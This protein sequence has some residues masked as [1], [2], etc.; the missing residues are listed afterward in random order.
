MNDEPY[1]YFDEMAIHSFVFLQ[2]AWSF[3]SDPIT[4]PVN[5][6]GR[7]KCSVYGAIGNCFDGPLLMYREKPTNGEDFLAYLKLLK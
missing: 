1:V 6:G 2:K 4:V 5:S 7:L 3:A